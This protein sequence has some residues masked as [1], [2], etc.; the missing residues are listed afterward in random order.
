MAAGSGQMRGCTSQPTQWPGA[1]LDLLIY[2]MAGDSTCLVGLRT[3]EH[4]ACVA[5][6]EECCHTAGRGWRRAKS[7]SL[8]TAHLFCVGLAYVYLQI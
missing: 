6:T 2:D 7:W 8:C 3:N 1:T 4:L 5:H